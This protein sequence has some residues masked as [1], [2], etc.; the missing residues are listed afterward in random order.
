M[1]AIGVIC[2]LVGVIML[3]ILGYKCGIDESNKRKQKEVN[4]LKKEMAFSLGYEETVSAYASNM[5]S[6]SL[7]VQSVKDIA[8]GTDSTTTLIV[9][10]TKVRINTDRLLGIKQSLK[11]DLEIAL[12]RFERKFGE[13]YT[14]SYLSGRAKADRDL[15]NVHANKDMFNYLRFDTFPE[16]KAKV[17]K[18]TNRT[19]IGSV[20]KP[21]ITPNQIKSEA[22]VMLEKTMRDCLGKPAHCLN[23]AD[24]EAR[25]ELHYGSQSITVYCRIVDGNTEFK[26]DDSEWDQQFPLSFLR[27]LPNYTQG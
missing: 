4:D 2:I 14:A 13:G 1:V 17:E 10:G 5:D 21:N 20:T 16:V 7:L 3:F 22:T 8:F 24:N 19:D 27:L 25:C 15:C 18:D 11:E 12:K 6:F 23:F 26:V 9:Q